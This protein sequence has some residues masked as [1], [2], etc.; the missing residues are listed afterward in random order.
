MSGPIKRLPK[1]LD[2]AGFEAD[3]LMRANR[4]RAEATRIAQQSDEKVYA[5][6]TKVLELAAAGADLNPELR[7]MAD[8]IKELRAAVERK[9]QELKAIN[10]ETWVEPA[11]APPPPPRPDPVAQRLQ[12]YVDAPQAG[13]FNCPKCGSLIRANA[14]FCPKCGRKILR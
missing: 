10:A 6:G 11:P 8:E 2:R 13:A 9:D 1:W 3:K 5:L 7:A 14:A 4:V 12:A